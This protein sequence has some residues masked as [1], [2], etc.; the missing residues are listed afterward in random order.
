[1]LLLLTSIAL[2]PSTFLPLRV[3]LL[4][5]KDGGRRG[6]NV[7][8]L[9]VR[10]HKQRS[11]EES[12]ERFGVDGHHRSKS[13]IASLC[14]RHTSSS[15]GSCEQRRHLRHSPM[16]HNSHQILDETIPRSKWRDQAA[17]ASSASSEHPKGLGN[18]A[19]VL[20]AIARRGLSAEVC[21]TAGVVVRHV[22]GVLAHC[23]AELRLRAQRNGVP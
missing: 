13:A 16:L 23:G 10:R 18:G 20:L 15:S 3:L 7:H 8:M 11:G 12:L 1:M 19:V 9:N 6:S 4:G 5:G 21:E 22:S 2:A 14:G 17:P